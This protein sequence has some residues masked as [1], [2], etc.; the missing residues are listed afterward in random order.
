MTRSVVAIAARAIAVLVAAAGAAAHA[1]PVAVVTDVRGGATLGAA[2]APAAILGQVSSG[3]RIGLPDGARVSLLYYT[4]GAQFD[5]RGPGAIVIDAARPRPEQ[6]AAVAPRAAGPAPA[7]RL[8]PGGLV[9]GALVMRSLGLRIATPESQV[10]SLRPPLAWTDSRADA[11]YDVALID[12]AGTRLFEATTPERRAV[13]PDA[14]ALEPG[15][16]YALEVKAR[17]GGAVVQVARAEFV[18]APDDLRAQARALAPAAD[19][20]V[21]DRVA[22]ALWLDQSAL[23]DEAQR[24]WVDLAR[25]RPEQG[26]LRGRAGVR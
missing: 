9:Q 20:D 1:Q 22:Y 7:P 3:D 15:A 17:V 16:S 6:G 23:L 8:A 10:L 24:W 2:G 25:A 12:A 14:L 19:A 18:V 26:A 4:S 5:A 13:L 11:T 21:A